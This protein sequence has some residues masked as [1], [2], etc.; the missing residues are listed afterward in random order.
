MLARTRPHS[1]YIHNFPENYAIQQLNNGF[2]DVIDEDMNGGVAHMTIVL[3]L[4][5]FVLT[6]ALSQ[7]LIPSQFR[8][9]RFSSSKVRHFL[10]IFG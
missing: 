2:S 9:K 5:V 6:V 8:P 10:V 3:V 1:A 7:I 4:I